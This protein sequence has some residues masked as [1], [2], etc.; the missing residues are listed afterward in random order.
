LK[1]IFLDLT[2]GIVVRLVVLDRAKLCL[3]PDY[4]IAS[5]TGGRFERQVKFIGEHGGRTE[6]KHRKKDP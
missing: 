4:F 5:Q 3:G 1:A 6:G 2:M